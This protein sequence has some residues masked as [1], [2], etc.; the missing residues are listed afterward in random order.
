[1]GTGSASLGGLVGALHGRTSILYKRVLSGKPI[2]IAKNWLALPKN[3]EILL[4][5]ARNELWINF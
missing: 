5:M 2:I 1:M 4:R 3:L